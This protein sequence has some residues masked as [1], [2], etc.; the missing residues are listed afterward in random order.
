MAALLYTI[1]LIG[2]LSIAL[3]W[4][5][6]QAIRLWSSGLPMTR[7]GAALVRESIRWIGLGL[8]GLSLWAVGWFPANAAARRLTLAGT[9][10]RASTL[11]KAYLYTGQLVTLAVG[12]TEVG[13]LTAEL[14]RRALS[15]L[16]VTLAPWPEWAVARA[17]GALVA[18]IFW[19]HLRWVAAHD[20]DF[21]A[22]RRAASGGPI[23]PGSFGGIC[24]GDCR[25]IGY[26][27]A[28]LGLAA[29][30][31]LTAWNPGALS[32]PAAAARA[33]I[34]SSVTDLV[35]GIPLAI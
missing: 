26:L 29:S 5:S 15:E 12:L 27:Q 30:V 16:S 10:E 25:A 31:L 23:L 2:L 14:L 13:L 6:G 11:R 1:A 34:V 24:P 7:T 3:C 35:I 32:V 8:V 19:G 22:F 21:D 18:F 17:A 20:G 4:C 9:A 28:M 33:P